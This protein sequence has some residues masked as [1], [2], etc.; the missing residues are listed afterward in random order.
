MGRGSAHQKRL[1]RNRLYRVHFRVECTRAPKDIKK[2][3]EIEGESM[4]WRVRSTL[5]KGVT[6]LR[7][8]WFDKCKKGALEKREKERQGKSIMLSV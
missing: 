3:L 7:R 2:S 5:W 4:L 1:K 8:L 6:E